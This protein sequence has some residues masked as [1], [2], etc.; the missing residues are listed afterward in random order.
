M[1][2]HNA[3]QMATS[4]PLRK[5]AMPLDVVVLPHDMFVPCE[6]PNPVPLHHFSSIPLSIGRALEY[7][8]YRSSID[9][10]GPLHIQVWRQYIL[11]AVATS[12]A[13]QHA[14]AALSG[15]HERHCF[16]TSAESKIGQEECWR[17]YYIAVVRTNAL[18]AAAQ[19]NEKQNRMIN[20]EILISC[21]IF[22]TIE[23]LLGNLET[24]IRHLEGGFLLIQTYINKKWTLLPGLYNKD[25]H[26]FQTNR[27]TTYSSCADIPQSSYPTHLDGHL[28]DLIGFFA[29]LDLQMLTFL[30]SGRYSASKPSNPPA[31]AISQ[32][33]QPLPNALSASLYRIIKQCLYWIRHYASAFR[34][35]PSIPA[36]LYEAQQTWLSA[37]K[38]WKASF[39]D[40]KQGIGFLAAAEVMQDT[41]TPETANLLLAYNLTFLKLHTALSA[42][43]LIFLTRECIDAFRTIL[44]HASTILTQRNEGSYFRDQDSSTQRRSSF[45]SLETSTIEPLYYTAIKCRHPAFRCR[46]LDL[47][48]I[49]GREGVWDG[50]IMSRVAS[51]V[52]LIEQGTVS[53]LGDIGQIAGSETRDKNADFRLGGGTECWGL[54]KEKMVNEITLDIDREKRVVNVECGWF[55]E[56]ER[57]WKHQAN[58][59]TW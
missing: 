57:S 51:H 40:G 53:S 25:K 36:E 56:E 38:A 52:I 12:P 21:A 55:L 16:P 17:Q 46:A 13:I 47:L 41:M 28:A 59:L 45:F 37:L 4:V 30:P 22:I 58:I 29:R 1:T 14:V 7:F 23:I 48:M 2:S 3:H 42:S 43:E 8:V 32:L 33:C 20:E 24:A 34:Y 50:H 19:E 26:S 35:S 11:S 15:F 5:N 27:P 10:T 54:E 9:L 39:L 44:V 18:M 31:Y 6:P 49:G